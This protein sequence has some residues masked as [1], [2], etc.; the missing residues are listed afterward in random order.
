MMKYSLKLVIIF[1]LL[2]ENKTCEYENIMMKVFQSLF[3]LEELNIKFLYMIWM[4][5]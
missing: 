2:N 3:Y 4:L 1:N 5:G